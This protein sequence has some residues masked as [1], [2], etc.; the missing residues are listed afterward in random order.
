MTLSCL[1]NTKKFVH[2]IFLLGDNLF[3]PHIYNIIQDITVGC[4][5]Y[6]LHAVIDNINLSMLSDASLTL[7][8]IFMYITQLHPF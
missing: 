5:Y 7:K 1:T 3:L 8:P 6:K 4:L 2:C